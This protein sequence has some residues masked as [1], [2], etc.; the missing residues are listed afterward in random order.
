MGEF[1]EGDF[2]NGEFSAREF[3]AHP[4]CDKYDLSVNF[5]RTFTASTFI[6]KQYLPPFI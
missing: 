6:K 1:D 5:K 3:S 2:S 4:W